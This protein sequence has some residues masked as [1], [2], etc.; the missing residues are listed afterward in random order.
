MQLFAVAE[1]IT[2]TGALD[3]FFRKVLGRPKTSAGAQIRMML[4]VGFWSAFLNNTPVVA[5]MIPI[6]SSWSRALKISP[7]QLMIP[8][9]Y[10]SELGGVC[11]LIGTSTNLI[12]K[13]LYDKAAAAAAEK[14][15]TLAT[16]SIFSQ[17]LYG[18]PICIMGMVYIVLLGRR[19]LPG[20]VPVDKKGV[21]PASV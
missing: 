10:V 5:L 14:G 12:V 18:V 3:A 7:G 17:S 15:E 9:S 19:I 6:V 8:L 11:T 2:Q 1:G 20:H 13:D 21:T 16:L 4:P